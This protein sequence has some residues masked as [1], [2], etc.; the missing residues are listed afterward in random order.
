ML[1]IYAI[2]LYASFMILLPVYVNSCDVSVI[3]I[4]FEVILVKFINDWKLF[5][6]FIG[7]IEIIYEN[8]SQDTITLTKK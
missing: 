2:Y 8:M 1:F 4:S 3:I 5:I 7:H 6:E